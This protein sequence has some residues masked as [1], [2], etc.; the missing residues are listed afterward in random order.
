MKETYRMS[1]FAKGKILE[2]FK[3]SET[4]R[5]S[6]L[7]MLMLSIT[8]T[9]FGQ[10]TVG[11][12]DSSSTAMPWVS[13]YGYTYNQMI[14]PQDQIGAAGTITSL[15]FTSTGTLP[16]SGSGGASPATPQGA[17]TDFKVFIGHTTKSSFESTTDWIAVGDMT[18]AFDGTLTMPTVSGQTLVVTLT[19]PF[20]YNNMD[21]LVIAFDE[22]SPGYSCSFSWVVSTGQTNR[23]IVYR[24]D[25]NN[26]DPDAPPTASFS[27]SVTPMVTLGGLVASNPPSC[28]TDISP[29]DMATDVALN[30][31]ISWTNP[32]APAASS[33]DVFFGTDAEPMLLGNF[34]SA[35]EA[36]NAL[37]SLLMAN[38]IYY[39]RVVP[40]N[41][42]GDAIDCVTT[43]FT[44][45]TSFV[46]CT[47]TNSS[48]CGFSGGDAITD[49]VV[50]SYS[51]P[52]GC[53]TPNNSTYLDTGIE[54]AL[55]TTATVAVSFGSDSNQYSAI[56]IDFNQDGT[57]D[58]SEGVL[59][60][61][62]A[63]GSGTATF[64][65]MIPV[66][67]ILG[68][69]R[70][71]IRGGND[72]A[73]SLTQACGAGAG[74]W[75]ESEDYEI[76]ILEA[77][78]NPPSCV[79]TVEPADAATDVVRNGSLT[80]SG[81][82]GFPT[83]FD[84]YFGTSED[85]EFVM[86]V[87][88]ASYDPGTLMSNTTYY[89]KIV[90]KNEN[91][92]A[93]GCSVQSF[94]T[95]TGFN[96]CASNS[97][98]SA[99]TKV[100]SFTLAGMTKGAADGCVTY[101][102]R[103]A[104]APF[105]LQQGVGV[106]VSVA[107]GTCSFSFYGSYAKVFVDV[108]QNGTFE[109][110]E[111]FYGGSLTSSAPGNVTSGTLTL[112]MSALLGN[113]R[114]R[115]VL[116]ESGSDVS[117]TACGTYGYGET[118]DYTVTVIEPLPTTQ[119]RTQFCNTTLT[120]LNENIYASVI[121]GASMYKFKVVNGEEVQEINR[122]NSRF[123][124]GFASGIMAGTT[125]EVSVATE[126]DGIWSGYGAACN[127]TTPMVYPTTQLR[128]E[129]CNTT[130]TTLNENIY[131]DFVVGAS[132]YKFK[133]VNGMNEQEIERPDSRFSMAFATG[134][135]A[136]TTYDV[137]VA[138]MFNGVWSEY[139]SV[140]TVTTPAALPTTQLHSSFC[141]GTVSS[142]GS[143][144]YAS[145]IV[146]AT[147]YKFKTMINGEDVEVVRPNA[148]CFMVAFPGAMMDQTYSIEV[149]VQIGGV[150]S[151]YGTACNLTVGTS[152]VSK[153]DVSGAAQAFDIKA[154]PNPFMNQITLSLSNENTQSDIMVYDM[155]GKLI[156]QIAT[157]ETSLEIGNDWSKGIYLV[158]IVQG[159]ETKSVRIVKQ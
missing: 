68:T 26:P 34:M 49:V 15:T 57:F 97:T 67:A 42:A 80:W 7:L 53:S 17:N 113:T 50:G 55:G 75:G 66:D 115:L 89:W 141:N 90:P 58:E 148:R 51:N 71:R 24:S 86:N 142:L 111:M 109:D 22:N 122:P 136:G 62:N 147:A 81:A 37:P 32:T 140:C 149:A 104:D 100:G 128:P 20:E 110:E 27:E 137:S 92:D 48:G 36:S 10:V 76:T 156:Q 102:D 138:T 59:S 28:V 158:Q 54:F 129:Y 4:S 127:I 1:G 74:T 44:T 108:N 13:C 33:Y 87:M 123:S 39:V 77:P 56:W 120:T 88:D 16:T 11:I 103:T 150:W 117:T 133:V 125:Y 8:F 159:Q 134:I 41:D 152:G 29:A 154:Y 96:Y 135:M 40:K 114:L 93:E 60:D 146:G 14:Y 23:G 119:L 70:M 3:K 124:M 132:M 151:E 121:V 155:T 63:G 95:G 61:G 112:P 31:D 130:L 72:S 79:S 82:T 19:T 78:V 144:F 139:G 143:N 6:W 18:L 126:V 64:N 99:D 21:N 105:V 107:L 94:T 25:S 35:P 153:Q 84:V 145:G 85:P 38:T 65:I 46:Y 157:E 83:S 43:S 9:G 98:D 45:G 30:T 116:R 12:G 131:A 118:Q 2:L 106:P 69:T 5:T 47:P 73:L 52:T 101:T 91:G